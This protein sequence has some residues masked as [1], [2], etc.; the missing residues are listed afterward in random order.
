MKFLPNLLRQNTYFVSK[1]VLRA[2]LS[3]SSCVALSRLPSTYSFCCQ[4]TIHEPSKRIIFHKRHHPAH[5]LHNLLVL[6]VFLLQH[7]AHLI[8]KPPCRA[9]PNWTVDTLL[10]LSLPSYPPASPSPR[11]PCLPS[12]SRRP[13][14]SKPLCQAQPNTLL[15][16]SLPSCPP[17]SPHLLILR[18]FLLHHVAHLLQNLLVVH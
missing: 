7:V 12:T 14:P 10:S 2:C 9:Q 16:R 13:L 17:V 1:N 18:V 8:P 11:P 5:L 6:L 3:N 4:S 15:S